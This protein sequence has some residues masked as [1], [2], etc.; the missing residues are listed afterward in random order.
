MTP[1]EVLQAATHDG[2]RILGLEQDLGSIE[3]GKLADLVVLDRNPLDNIRH[4]VAIRYVMKNGA[5]YEAETL[6][7]V[8]PTEKELAP[9]WWWQ[10]GPR[11]HRFAQ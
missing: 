9:F 11:R 2:A 5:H 10:G 1:R 6:K 8:W 7:Q 4:S 3:V